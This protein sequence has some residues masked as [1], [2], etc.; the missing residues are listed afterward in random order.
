MVFLV[1]GGGSQGHHIGTRG[2]LGDGEPP[3]IVRADQPG[4]VLPP[5]CLG[6]VPKN[7]KRAPHRLHVD[8]DAEGAAGAANLF[9]QDHG[10]EPAHI[11]SPVFLGDHG[12]KE[13][14]LRHGLDDFLIGEIVLFVP[15][16]DEGRDLFS[17]EVPGDL[18]EGFQFVRQLERHIVHPP[19]SRVRQG[20][21]DN[22]TA[23]GGKRS[24]ACEGVEFDSVARAWYRAAVPRQTD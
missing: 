7:R 14:Q 19:G 8:L 24:G 21:Y 10:R 22:T 15:L 18:H 17:A 11:V 3:H 4:D 16:L 13:A 6:P 23:T 9:G 5:E 1:R 2:G 12:A 20:P